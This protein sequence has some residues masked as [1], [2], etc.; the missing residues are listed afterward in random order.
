MILCNRI[1]VSGFV[2]KV[3]KPGVNAWFVINFAPM[4]LLCRCKKKDPTFIKSNISIST[5]TGWVAP[6]S[7]GQT[8]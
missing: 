2:V 7:A 5:A 4:S 3:Q 6:G 1:D 8:K